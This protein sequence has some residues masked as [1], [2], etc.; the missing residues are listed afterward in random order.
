MP[1]PFTDLVLIIDDDRPTRDGLRELLEAE[2]YAVA[3]AV[4][5]NAAL[6]RLR[7]GLRPRVI[8]LD[9]MM[10]NGDGWDFR[11]EQLRDP[12]LKDIPVLILTAAGF[13]R[14]SVRVQFGDT[15]FIPKPP[16]PP[17]LLAAINQRCRPA[18]N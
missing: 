18:H 4:N 1:R 5:G 16:P 3:E 10:P 2:G 17:A 14:E 8:V 6:A 13:S 9:L 7:R 11:T 12:A 15:E